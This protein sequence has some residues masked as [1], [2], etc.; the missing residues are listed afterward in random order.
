MKNISSN[1][2]SEHNDPARLTRAE[3]LLKTMNGLEYSQRQ[4]H[5]ALQPIFFEKDHYQE[6]CTTVIKLAKLIERTALD[7]L[8]SA[9]VT[10][11]GIG[12]IPT[13][14]DYRSHRFDYLAAK[15][16]RADIIFSSGVPKL[17]EFNF[18]SL[19][20]G[21]TETHMLQAFFM[22]NHEHRDPL[23]LRRDELLL[24]KFSQLLRTTL[25]KEN[26]HI[27]LLGLKEDCTRYFPRFYSEVNQFLRGQ[28]IASS[29]LDPEELTIDD[30]TVIL[31]GLAVD[32]VIRMYQLQDVVK[33]GRS[34]A[35]Y[36][37]IESSINK[38][39]FITTNHCQLLTSKYILG[40]LWAHRDEYS[41]EEAALIKNHIPKSYNLSASVMSEAM[42]SHY[43][44]ELLNQQADFV[45]KKKDSNMGFNVFIG[46]QLSSTQWLTVI[47]QAL[48]S[49]DYVAQE[50]INSDRFKMRFSTEQGNVCEEYLEAIIGPYVLDSE[51]A[52]IIVRLIKEGSKALTWNDKNALTVL[53]PIV[54]EETCNGESRGCTHRIATGC[55]SRA[56]SR[57]HN[58]PTF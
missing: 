14:N 46:R 50:Y 58:V 54:K 41:S 15:M 9:P 16:G 42:L 44:D 29:I 57:T 31:N 22:D 24:H 53:L 3:A 52:G 38:T 11:L 17:L 35:A 1:S 33:Y 34:S 4:E 36:L 7:I 51:V 12:D 20:G 55:S 28:G 2:F 32:A 27:I 19:L 26:P 49:G 56:K 6:L 23:A 8:K 37:D 48:A 5:L 30:G 13:V 40:Y 18:N 21:F 25:K 39:A 43:R 47:N 45:L 10:T